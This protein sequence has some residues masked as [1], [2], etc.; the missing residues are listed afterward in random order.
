MIPHISSY[1]ADMRNMYI[2]KKEQSETVWRLKLSSP[3]ILEMP[4]Y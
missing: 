1:N 3:K 2:P 4:L